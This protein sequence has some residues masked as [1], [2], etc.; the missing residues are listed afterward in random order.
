MIEWNDL[1]VLIREKLEFGLECLLLIEC[2]ATTYT[3]PGFD[4]QQ[5]PHPSK[6]NEQTKPI[7]ATQT[8]ELLNAK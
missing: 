7:T 2:V 5:C 6:T 1:Q 3:G 8:F 4:P